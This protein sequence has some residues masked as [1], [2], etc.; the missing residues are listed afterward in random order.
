M[1]SYF[2]GK[3]ADP[4]SFEIDFD[5]KV[6]N[7]VDG[8]TMKITAMSGASIFAKDKDG[9]NYSLDRGT[10]DLTTFEQEPIGSHTVHIL[11]DYQCQPGKPKF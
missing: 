3:K 8:V 2:D 9:N 4:L 7:T 5:R 1:S 6:I 10:G 11:S